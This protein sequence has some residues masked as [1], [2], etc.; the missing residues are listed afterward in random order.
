M[1]QFMKRWR[2]VWLTAFLIG[3]LAFLAGGWRGVEIV[4]FLFLF[5][6][7]GNEHQNRNLA[8]RLAASEAARALT[9][10]QYAARRHRRLI[11][12][13]RASRLRVQQ[14]FTIIAAQ[15]SIARIKTANGKIHSLLIDGVL[16]V[17]ATEA[18]Q[19]PAREG[20]DFDFP[21]TIG[22]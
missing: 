18:T 21:E 1:I 19:P 6:S 22:E 10:Q 13:R 8:E 4:T 2:R 14:L 5:Y 16:F 17:Q 3:G 15:D 20:D 12:Y 7:V 9:F 11:R